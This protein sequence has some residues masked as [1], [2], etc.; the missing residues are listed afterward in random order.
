M[1][2]YKSLGAY[3]WVLEGWVINVKMLVTKYFPEKG[4]IPTLLYSFWSFFISYLINRWK[5]NFRVKQSFYMTEDFLFSGD[6]LPKIKWSI[7]RAM[8]YSSKFWGNSHSTL[9]LNGWL[10]RDLYSC[11]IL[12]FLDGNF[13]KNQRIFYC[14]SCLSGCTIKSKPSP[15][16]K[17]SGHWLL[18]SKKK[19]N[20]NSPLYSRGSTTG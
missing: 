14:N 20:W 3:N 8:W 15:T 18:S 6:A 10:G 5:P 7:I 12:A 11:C 2:A 19:K 13:N 9:Q 17:N 16:T 1:K 4:E